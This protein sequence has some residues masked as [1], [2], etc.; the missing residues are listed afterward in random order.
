MFYK[1]QS[2]GHAIVAAGERNCWPLPSHVHLSPEVGTS[3]RYLNSGSIF[4][5]ADAWLAA[6]DAMQEKEQ[7]LKGQPFER[8]SNGFHIFN[9]DQAA[10]SDLYVN[11]EADIV[12]DS[13]CTLFQALF[14]TDCQI[15]AANR[16]FVFEG[17]RIVNRE[18]GAR[19]CL[20]HANGSIPLEPWAGY[21]LNPPVVWIWPLVDR[22]RSAD[23]TS[24]GDAAFVEHLLLELGL[25]DAIDGHMPDWLLAYTGKG[26]SIWQ[27]PNEFAR[28]LVWLAARPPIRSYLEIGVESGGSFIATTEYLRRFHP[29]RVAIGVDPVLSP[30]VFDYVSRSDGVYFI[31]GTQASDD[32]RWLIEQV[33]GLDLVFIDG[34]HSPDGVR[35]DWEFT[36][37]RSRCVAFHDIVAESLPGVAS[38]WKQIRS[39]HSKTWEFVDSEWRPNLWA[40]I[41]A[42]DL[43]LDRR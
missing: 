21:V 13:R 37:S 17:R 20:I 2:F 35:A 14:R 3:V 39:T 10:W 43:H 4:S 30:P 8:S 19:P 31:Q 5:T 36:R 32:L 11:R 9:C 42:V 16:D 28:Y 12:L 22:I 23:L 27:R 24:L 29:L 40:G 33:G 1:Y 26:L 18:S 6:W 34:D 15:A 38:L 25:H 7:R 41:G